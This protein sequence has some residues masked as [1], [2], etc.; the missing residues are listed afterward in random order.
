MNILCVDDEA[1]VRF[2]YQLIFKKTD[3]IV[4]YAISAEDVLERFCYTINNFDVIITDYMMTG[5]DGV[6]LLIRLRGCGYHGKAV[7]CTSNTTFD[8][9]IIPENLETCPYILKPFNLTSFENAINCEPCVKFC[10][11]RK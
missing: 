7:V 3:Y 8:V 11:V 9:G 1:D 10:T 5:M 2:L 4:E 6:E